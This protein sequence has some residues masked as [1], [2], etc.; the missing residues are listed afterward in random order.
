MNESVKLSVIEHSLKRG[1]TKKKKN[2]ISGVEEMEKE[3]PKSRKR[4]R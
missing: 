3:G 2:I 1:Y 4:L